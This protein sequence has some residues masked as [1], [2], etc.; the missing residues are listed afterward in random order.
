MDSS[1]GTNP[2]SPSSLDSPGDQARFRQVLG[3]FP[4]SVV[5]IT[6]TMPDGRPETM[7]VG[8]FTS[9]S[10]E[11]PLVAFL[12]DRS[13]RTFPKI[14]EAGRYC[15]NA[16]ASDQEILCRSM[17]T[18]GA[19]RFD[20]IPWQPSPLG[21]PV[22]DGVVAWVDCELEKVVEIGDHHLAVG[23]VRALRAE[24]A[25]TPL[26]FFRGG[27]GDYFSSASLVLDRLVGW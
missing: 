3:N 14:R 17:A 18:R 11:P 12:A 25:K 6:T 16:L 26:L 8:S 20:G 22:L 1:G 9:V 13:S 23:R 21:N 4:T 24:S 10:L 19:D 15:V 5:A 7:I 2:S 27:Y